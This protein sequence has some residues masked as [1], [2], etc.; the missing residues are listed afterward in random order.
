MISNE[1]I[2]IGER[3][4][5][6]NTTPTPQVKTKHQEAVGRLPFIYPLCCEVHQLLM[7]TVISEVTLQEKARAD[8]S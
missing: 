2:V 3:G 1:K 4:R 5:K 8:H 7:T 6:K